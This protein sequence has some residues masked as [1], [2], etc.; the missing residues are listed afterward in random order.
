MGSKSL[1][2]IIEPTKIDRPELNKL[3]SLLE[4]GDTLMF[5]KLDRVARSAIEGS[6][7]IL[8]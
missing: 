8:F 7:L 6:K 3:L 5:T 4:D 1:T 2:A